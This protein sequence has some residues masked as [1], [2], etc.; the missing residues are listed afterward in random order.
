MVP[1]DPKES[2]ED[3]DGRW[4]V[5]LVR[6]RGLWIADVGRDSS[7]LSVVTMGEPNVDRLD[8]TGVVGRGDET[9]RTA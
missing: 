4:A 3:T 9:C 5:M 2:V 7:L 6:S 8:V 1:V